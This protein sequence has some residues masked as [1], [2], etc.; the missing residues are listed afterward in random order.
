[1]SRSPRI[2]DRSAAERKVYGQKRWMSVVLVDRDQTLVVRGERLRV[3]RRKN[4]MKR[5]ARVSMR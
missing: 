1:M 3:S 5:A 2:V 4:G